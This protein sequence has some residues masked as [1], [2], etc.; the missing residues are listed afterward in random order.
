MFLMGMKKP[1]IV[2]TAFSY[3]AAQIPNACNLLLN[4][5]IA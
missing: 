2:R 3:L 4:V 5:S 1:D